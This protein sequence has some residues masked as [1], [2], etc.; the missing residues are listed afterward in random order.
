[1]TQ[2]GKYIPRYRTVSK[3]PSPEHIQKWTSAEVIKVDKWKKK[4]KCIKCIPSVPDP[5]HFG[6]DPDPDVFYAYSFLRAHLHHSS[7]KETL[8]KSKRSHKPVD[9][10]NFFCLLM[11][12]S[13]FGAGS[14]HINYGNGSRRSKNIWIRLRIRNSLEYRGP[15]VCHLYHKMPYRYRIMEVKIFGPRF[16]LTVVNGTCLLK[17][18]FTQEKKINIRIRSVKRCKNRIKLI[19]SKIFKRQN[20][21]KGGPEMSIYV[22]NRLKN[23]LA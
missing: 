12:G 4:L 3:V 17:R 20:R 19:F 5:W 7:R 11:E 8:R 16:T 21:K 13:G 10:S 18:C 2:I 23:I 22:R 1:M 14:V 15:M 6:T 9:F